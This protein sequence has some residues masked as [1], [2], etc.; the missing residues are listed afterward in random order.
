M[1]RERFPQERLAGA[2][3]AAS[4]MGLGLYVG[5]VVA[6]ALPGV[7]QP[8]EVVA[9]SAAGLVLG[10]LVGLALRRGDL[11]WRPLLL[12]WGYVLWPAASPTIAWELGLAALVAWVWALPGRGLPRFAV[13]GVVLGAGL[14]LYG[15]TVAPTVLPADS[16]EFQLVAAVWGIAH[17]PGYALYT[18]LGGV[19]SRLVPAEPALALNLL[20]VLLGALTPPAIVALVRSTEHASARGAAWGGTLAALALAVSPT[21]W[22]QATTANIRSLTTLLTAL[23]VLL[24]IRW[25]RRATSGRLAAVGLVFGLAVGHH[26]S[27]AL[28]ALPFGA[29]VLATEPR[30]PLAP[31]RWLPALGAFAASF[32]VLLYLPLRSAM[33]PPFDPVPVN[34]VARF[35]EHV[36][37]TGFRGDMLYY[38]SLPQ[39][40]ER[41]RIYGNILQLQFGPVLPWAMI[42]SLLIV[43]RRDWR[44]GLLLGGVWLVNA[45]SA[46]TYRAPQTVEYLLPSYVAMVACLGCGLAWAL[47]RLP[48][49]APEALL[50]CLSL[51]VALNALAAWPSF[52]ALHASRDARNYAETLLL[53]APQNALV[54]A[55]WHWATPLWYLQQAEGLR[56]DV[57]VEYVYPQGAL[58]NE[59]VWL[60]R[61]AEGLALG[62][63]AARPVIVTNWFHAYEAAPYQWEP[64]GQAWL[65]RAEPLAAPPPQ[66]EE[67]GVGLGGR[68]LVEAYQLDTASIS[69]GGNLRVTVYWRPLVALDHDYAVSVQLV[70]P[71]GMIGQADRAQPTRSYPAG[72]LRID[73]YELPVLLQAAPGRY[74]LIVGF[75]RVTDTGWE[76][77]QTA[78]GVDHVALGDIQVTAGSQRVA[79]TTP[80]AVSYAVGVRLRGMDLDRSVPGQA[81]LYLH[82][83]CEAS[84]AV[85]PL[86]VLALDGDQALAEAFLPPLVRGQTAILA[87]DLPEALE[88]VRLEVREGKGAQVRA[89]AP[90]GLAGR[91]SITLALPPGPRHYV[92]LGG[93]LVYLGL[94]DAP[95]VVVAGEAVTLRPRLMALRPLLRD[96][97]LSVGLVGQEPFWERKD[98]GTPAWG[99]IPTLKWLSGWAVSSPH[100][101]APPEEAPSGWAD[102]TLSAYDA[103]TLAPLAVLDERLAR[104][105]QGVFLRVGTILVQA[106]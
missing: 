71:Q 2:G 64:L 65:V 61:I 6:E 46:L 74:S 88:Q 105:G 20:S 54:L 96:Y 35:F 93:E 70:G 52:Q 3:R 1:A 22:S 48:R 78:N 5:R 49:P 67:V 10:A 41:G 103:F 12:L 55:N 37:A 16:G 57:S 91:V 72:A 51:A 43:L 56:P 85:G 66:A 53:E 102:I 18:L 8:W 27:L 92:P 79:T 104:E 15:A 11:P 44:L 63:R 83:L 7:R 82:W 98:D 97:S 38:T 21:F 47:E 17:P 106:R 9:L 42:L 24:L 81:R 19:F 69:P 28:L 75:Y 100:M 23:C 34:S 84:Q 59:K 31:R 86:H 95:E 33:G 26:S 101:L 99:A 30:L 77:L 29:F 58:P 36:L 89:L 68:V 4:W 32:L 14:V 40:I 80:M 87:L 73:E 45:A 76:R 90:W 94:G 25:A 13:E 62:E 39:L 60:D 50:A